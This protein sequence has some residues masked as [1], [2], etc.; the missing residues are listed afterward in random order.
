MNSQRGQIATGET[1]GTPEKPEE[2]VISKR[3]APGRPSRLS[4]DQIIETALTLI[5]EDGLTTFSLTRLARRLGISVMALYTYFPSR[6]AMLDAVTD[7]IF[8]EFV[9]PPATGAWQERLEA[10]IRSIHQLFARRPIGLKLVRQQQGI[11]P[12]WWQN[13]VPMVQILE[14]AGLTGADLSFAATWVG[15]NVISTVFSDVIRP[16]IT[17]VATQ[18]RMNGIEPEAA[19]RLEKVVAYAGPDQDGQ[20]LAFSIAK[21][22]ETAEALV[23]A[24]GKA[25]N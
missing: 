20:L 19:R 4:R 7:S 8:A 18:A 10:W 12:S 15:E 2:Q 13:W 1:V 14:E 6:E 3:R 11:F 21:I 5:E 25:A 24:S 16:E 23:A 17:I 9:A 22:I